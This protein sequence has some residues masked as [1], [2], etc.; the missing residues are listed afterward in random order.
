VSGTREEVGAP[1]PHLILVGLPGAG[2]TTVG[3][4]VAARL[5]R[6][7][8]D[9]DREIEARA[10]RSVAELFAAVGEAEF[11]RRERELTAELAERSGM[12]LAPGGG[13][14]AD[15]AAVALIRPPGRIILLAVSPETAFQRLLEGGEVG[16]RPLLSGGDPLVAM[17]RLAERREAAYRSADTVVDTENKTPQQVIEEVSSL[18]WPDGHG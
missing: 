7:F 8:M 5:G 11:R 9:F 15:D 2:K 18:A 10:G 12:V 13:W 16:R 6:P 14:V 4:A 1:T 3:E 17:R